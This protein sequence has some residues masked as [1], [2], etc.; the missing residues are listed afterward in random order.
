MIRNILILCIYEKSIFVS[1][2]KKD[3]AVTIEQ[4]SVELIITSDC[5]NWILENIKIKQR[6]YDSFS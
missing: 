3:L 1:S 2:K 4:K 6:I 5:N